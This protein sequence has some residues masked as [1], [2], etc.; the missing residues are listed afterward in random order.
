MRHLGMEAAGA[1]ATEDALYRYYS[2]GYPRPALDVTGFEQAF[3][4]VTIDGFSGTIGD[5]VFRFELEDQSHSLVVTRND[6]EV[7]RHPL[8][9]L[10]ARVRRNVDTPAGSNVPGDS[11][12][13]DAVGNGY[14][15]RLYLHQF[16][17]DMRSEPSALTA[18]MGDVL[19]RRITDGGEPP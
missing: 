8:A 4:N 17:E 12:R 3:T 7:I 1:A 10:L 9:P 15:V 11:M 2:A 6:E 5:D 19:L 18:A 13:I 14:A 16:T